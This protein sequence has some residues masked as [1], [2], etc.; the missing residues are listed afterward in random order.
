M[1]AGRTMA[2]KCQADADV[3]ATFRKIRG[4]FRIVLWLASASLVMT[5][6]L[7]ISV[8]FMSVHL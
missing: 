3:D 4:A 2:P 5:F 8:F 1:R 7:F 6:I